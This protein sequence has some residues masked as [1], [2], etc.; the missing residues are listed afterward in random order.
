MKNWKDFIDKNG[1]NLKILIEIFCQK[2]IVS[3]VTSAFL[4]HLK[5]TFFSPA[6]HGGRHRAPSLLKISGSAPENDAWD[7]MIY[8]KGN[9]KEILGRNGLR[10]YQKQ[11]PWGVL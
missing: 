6:I 9:G 4:D 10:I 1:E 3:N 11:L 8:L 5:N 2:L 7:L